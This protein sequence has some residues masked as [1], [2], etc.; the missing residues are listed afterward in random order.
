MIELSEF[1]FKEFSHYSEAG[2]IEEEI[3]LL[4]VLLRLGVSNIYLCHLL[5]LLFLR[6]FNI[7][8]WLSVLD[9]FFSNSIL[10]LLLCIILCWLLLHQHSLFERYASRLSNYCNSLSWYLYGT[11]I[12]I[13]CWKVQV[14]NWL[15]VSFAILVINAFLASLKQMSL[16]HW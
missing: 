4:V 6:S 1:I 7:L 13:L 15:F 5:L 10:H 2:P 3:K 11:F 16:Y 14:R 12:A 9:F 8:R